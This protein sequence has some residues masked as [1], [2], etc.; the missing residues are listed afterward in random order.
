MNVLLF[1]ADT[2]STGS[3]CNICCQ[4]HRSSHCLTFSVA[5]LL[6]FTGPH[7]IYSVTIM[8]CAFTHMVSRK[9][10]ADQKRSMQSVYPTVRTDIQQDLPGLLLVNT[11]LPFCMTAGISPAEY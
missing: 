4:A 7:L 6:E 5:G 1:P 10:S 3:V 9:S 2:R 11:L 8:P